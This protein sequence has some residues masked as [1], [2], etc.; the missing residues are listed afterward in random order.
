MDRVARFGLIDL[1]VADL[2]RLAERRL[3]HG[4]FGFEALSGDAAECDLEPLLAAVA[5]AIVQCARSRWDGPSH[6][7]QARVT[8]MKLAASGDERV[9]AAASEALTG[10]EDD[11]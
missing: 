1:G 6:S 2:V 11:A 7:S 10:L 9:S 3:G 5:G 4:P 8:L